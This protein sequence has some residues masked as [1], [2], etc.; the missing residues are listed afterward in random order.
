MTVSC[1]PVIAPPKKK[2]KAKKKTK[3]NQ[4]KSAKKIKKKRLKNTISGVF[5][6]DFISMKIRK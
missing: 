6:V 1:G 3:E 2:Q 5:F 4:Q